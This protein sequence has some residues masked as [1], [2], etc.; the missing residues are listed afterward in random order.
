MSKNI[1]KISE[2][3]NKVITFRGNIIE[4]GLDLT[5]PII[6]K[7]NEYFSEK[8]IN[9]EK[10]DSVEL[11]KRAETIGL[12]LVNNKTGYKIDFDLTKYGEDIN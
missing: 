1:K 5:I 3:N 6:K 9:S 8:I 7:F 4:C 11:K 10:L 12:D 2:S